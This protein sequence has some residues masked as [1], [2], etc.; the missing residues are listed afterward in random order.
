MCAFAVGRVCL[1]AHARRTCLIANS[2]RPTA[3][4]PIA[5]H[6]SGLRHNPG[7]AQINGE[8]T[9]ETG[10]GGGDV[11]RGTPSPSNVEGTLRCG[12]HTAAGLSGRDVVLVWWYLRG[13]ARG[14]WR[15]AVG[16]DAAQAGGTRLR[17]FRGTSLRCLRQYGYEKAVNGLPR[18]YSTL[19][20]YAGTLLSYTNANILRWNAIIL[21]AGTTILHYC[22]AYGRYWGTIYTTR[23]SSMIQLVTQGN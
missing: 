11:G 4:T 7:S 17:R 14:M 18:S 12:R 22:G 20:S 13:A 9:G 19:L 15:L 3:R 21:H 8:G 10:W 1:C 5:H 23:C 6:G 2:P 16:Q